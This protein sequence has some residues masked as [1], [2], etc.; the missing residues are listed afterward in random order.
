MLFRERYQKPLNLRKYFFLDSC[1]KCFTS[2]LWNFWTAEMPKKVRKR[3]INKSWRKNLTR[4][5]RNPED[6]VILGVKLGWN[7]EPVIPGL[8]TFINR[9]LCG[10][11]NYTEEPIKWLLDY[12]LES[13]QVGTLARNVGSDMLSAECWMS[14]CNFPHLVLSQSVHTWI[15][16]HQRHCQLSFYTPNTTMP[17]LKLACHFT[18]PNQTEHSSLNNEIQTCLSSLASPIMQL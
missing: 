2:C 8:Q 7:Y 16:A 3:V 4:F 14:Q 5:F 10:A 1:I 18:E 15:T 17:Q 9:D 12:D 6:T 13:R 11:S